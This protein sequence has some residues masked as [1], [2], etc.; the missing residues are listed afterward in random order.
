MIIASPV[1]VTHIGT[2]PW[3]GV[4]TRVVQNGARQKYEW[5]ERAAGSLED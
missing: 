5:A 3:R 1:V 2:H 4:I